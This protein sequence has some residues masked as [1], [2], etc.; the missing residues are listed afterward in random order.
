MK[1]QQGL[2]A[3][4]LILGVGLG[5]ILGHFL[6]PS[7][8]PQVA[9]PQVA[10]LCPVPFDTSMFF[11]SPLT[12]E[13]GSEEPDA[14][15]DHALEGLLPTTSPLQ[16][17]LAIKSA[18]EPDHETTSQLVPVHPSEN[19]P[20]T[21]KV[22]QAAPLAA[23]TARDRETIRGIIDI[24]LSHLPEEKRKV[25]F[26]ALKEVNKEDVAGI[27]RM[28]KLLGGPIP[29][30]PLAGPFS[31]DGL[32]A[33]GKTA[34]FNAF[35]PPPAVSGSPGDVDETL[36]LLEKA[37]EIHRNNVLYQMAPGHILQVPV[38]ARSS[39]GKL[40]LRVHEDFTA[41][42]A[43]PT[44]F[45]LDLAIK[46]NGFFV[47]QAE[48]GTRYFTRRGN[49][50]LDQ[51]RRI[52]LPD[53]DRLLVLQPEIVIPETGLSR[54][55]MINE[56]GEVSSQEQVGGKVELAESRKQLGTIQV[57]KV[58]QGDDLQ[59]VGNGL[60]VLSKE[61]QDHWLATTAVNDEVRIW[62]GTIE[63]PSFNFDLQ[64]MLSN[65]RESLPPS[66]SGR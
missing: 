64:K 1:M 22:E 11:S 38:F 42:R 16:N 2:F 26:D 46:G 10:G 8:L 31:G 29:E 58:L 43:V 35:E 32:T 59:N 44:G 34:P 62:S 49:F 53:G 17:A 56:L 27:L 6:R 54:T 63:L 23:N 36:Q 28:W 48:E 40:E 15:L 65:M 24:E 14:E 47:V 21:L 50:T 60:Y 57:A 13:R 3:S 12:N 41:V 37:Y 19:E 51:Q 61:K 66:T 55:F 20:G 45:P 4:G 52:A 7:S 18:R 33:T 25:W 30:V 9:P 39:S 5:L